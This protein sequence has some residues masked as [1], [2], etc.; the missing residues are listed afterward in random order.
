MDILL[1]NRPDLT[2]S[3][4]ESEDEVS[5]SIIVDTNGGEA[6]VIESTDE[7]MDKDTSHQTPRRQPQRNRV[8]PRSAEMV[9]WTSREYKNKSVANLAAAW[10]KVWKQWNQI[11][12]KSNRQLAHIVDNF[13]EEL[14][15]IR[16]FELWNEKYQEYDGSRAYCAWVRFGIEKRIRE[17]LQNKEFENLA[18]CL[19][20]A[21]QR[22]QKAEE[23][24]R[25]IEVTMK[26]GDSKDRDYMPT[27][28][29][30]HRMKKSTKLT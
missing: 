3:G 20:R 28:T 16:E 23:E 5:E 27:T 13:H 18:R 30:H 22:L 7:E 21:L 6:I 17:Q 1:T 11:R 24:H 25:S 9:D 12:A 4:S 2:S 19:R 26:D 15:D 10:A 29:R 8:L 14:S